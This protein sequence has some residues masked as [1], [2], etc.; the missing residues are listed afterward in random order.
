MKIGSEDRK[1]LIAASV[2]GVLALG[3]LVWTLVGSSGGA[4]SPD[5]STAPVPVVAVRSRGTAATPT[6]HLPSSKLDPSLHPEGMLLAEALPYTGTGRN[7]FLPPDVA[8]AQEAA[9]IPKPVQTARYV[10]PAPAYTGPP[11]PPP[12]N[13]KFFGTATRRDGTKKAFLLEGEDVFVAS[14]GDIVSRR[15]K[16]GAISA[17]AVEVTDMAN[18]NTQR[19][20]MAPQ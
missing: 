11:P 12:I 8:A 6:A 3:Y 10:P 19:L 1:K 13:L 2:F 20:P 15:Y 7:I 16:V 5:T 4:S 18:N 14:P 9:A 17:N